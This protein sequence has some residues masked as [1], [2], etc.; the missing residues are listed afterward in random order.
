MFHRAAYAVALVLAVALV[1]CCV[2]GAPQT[3]LASWHDCIEFF[4]MIMHDP[5]SMSSRNLQRVSSSMTLQ[6]CVHPKSAPKPLPVIASV[7]GEHM[8]ASDLVWPAV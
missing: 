7:C 1:P 5:S 4:E 6:A 8:P 2:L 3:Y